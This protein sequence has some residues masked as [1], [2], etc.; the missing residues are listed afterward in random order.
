MEE[1]M[2][3]MSEFISLDTSYAL[4]SFLFKAFYNGCE[5]ATGKREHWTNAP[6]KILQGE[7]NSLSQQFLFLNA[8]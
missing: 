4:Q 5:R 2:E 1:S 8:I 7:S 6:Y 3:E